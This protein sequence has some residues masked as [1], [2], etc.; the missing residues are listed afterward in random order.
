MPPTQNEQL[1]QAYFRMVQEDDYAGVGSIVT[2]D[3][4]WTIMPI[5]HTWSGRR[6]IESMALAAGRSRRHDQRSHVEIKNWFTDGEHLCVEY[7]HKLIVGGLGLR[8][9]VDGYCFVFHMREGRFDAI[10]EYINPPNA[11]AGLAMYALLP[12]LPW[13]SRRSAAPRSG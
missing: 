6:A 13:M 3:A 12:L 9:T 8:L 5:G 1:I 2:D 11:A 4:T 7:K 10:R